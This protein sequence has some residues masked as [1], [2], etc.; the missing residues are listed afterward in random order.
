[1]DLLREGFAVAWQRV[2]TGDPETYHALRV[3]LVTSML[4]VLIASV[5]AIPLGAWLGLFRPRGCRL[6]VFLARLGLA[7]P[8]V[9]IGL[10]LWALISRRGLLGEWGLLYSQTAITIGLTA[11]ALPILVT[12]VHATTRALDPRVRDTMRSLGAGRWRTMLWALGEVRPALATALLTAFYRCL[13]ELGVALI[14]GGGIRFD[15]RT[16][17]AQVTLEISK[18]EFGTA[19]APALLLLSVALLA[20]FLT[21]WALDEERA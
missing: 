1:M 18:G 12:W 11:L 17:P 5:V 4:A 14:V 15:T 19:L 2:T 7:V 13:T 3:S 9:V 10:L 21:P 6:M 8:T 16:L 20:T